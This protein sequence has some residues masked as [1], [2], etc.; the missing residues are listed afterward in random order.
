MQWLRGCR[1]RWWG[2]GAQAEAGD[3]GWD[4]VGLDLKGAECFGA[5]WGLVAQAEDEQAGL[6]FFG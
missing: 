1:L 4:G 5:G 2:D 6:D 3:A